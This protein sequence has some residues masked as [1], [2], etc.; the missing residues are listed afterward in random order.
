MYK[1]YII[2]TVSK[3]IVSA[4]KVRSILKDFLAWLILLLECWISCH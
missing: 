4:L 3:I 2:R 1:V